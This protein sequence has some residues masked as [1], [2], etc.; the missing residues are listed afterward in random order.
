MSGKATNWSNLTSILS[1][2]FDVSIF[3]WCVQFK[4][5]FFSWITVTFFVI[6][7]KRHISVIILATWTD[8]LKERTTLQAKWRYLSNIT[9]WFAQVEKSNLSCFIS[10]PKMTSHI[11]SVS[12]LLV[13]ALSCRISASALTS[14]KIPALINNN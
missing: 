11:A 14:G 5:V 9:K 2:S 3:L 12:I 4:Y 13:L 10:N 7:I 8:H 6:R 1:V